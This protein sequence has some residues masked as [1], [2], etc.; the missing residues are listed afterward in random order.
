MPDEDSL[1]TQVACGDFEALG[2]DELADVFEG[3]LDGYMLIGGN[4]DPIDG[5]YLPRNSDLPGEIATE[6]VELS[7]VPQLVLVG[8]TL[9]WHHTPSPPDTFTGEIGPSTAIEQIF[10]RG[11]DPDLPFIAVISSDCGG[12]AVSGTAEF[13]PDGTALVKHPLF[14][15]GPCQVGDVGVLIDPESDNPRLILIPPGSLEAGGFFEVGQEEQEAGPLALDLYPQFTGLE[16]I[17]PGWSDSV[18]LISE[19][20]GGVEPSAP[21]CNL[22][23]EPDAVRG[24]TLNFTRDGAENCAEQFWV[25]AA[26]QTDLDV[27]LTVEETV[28]GHFATFINP[29]GE[30]RPALADTI[31][32]A[33]ITALFDGRDG[34]P[35][36]AIFPC[37]F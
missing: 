20:F 31:D 12:Q 5:S 11:T 9:G 17:D 36:T 18:Q 28:T 16:P 26:G 7:L 30:V 8:P 1:D 19:V 32:I 15:F 27:E 6:I 23:V 21:G 35:A 34:T 2:F 29:L 33:P 10:Y 14:D 25:F 22:V 3:D 4:C 13:E 37:G 24:S